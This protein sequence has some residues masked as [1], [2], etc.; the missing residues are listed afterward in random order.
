M[1]ILLDVNLIMEYY[2]HRD[3][4]VEASKVL[5]A[6]QQG[7][8]N[9]YLSA[10]TFDTLTYLIGNELKRQGIHEPLK[11]DTTRGMLNRLLDYLS[12]VDISQDFLSKGLND[13]SFKDL[14][15]AYQYYCAIENE[16]D[17]IITINTKDFAGEHKEKIPVYSLTE[18]VGNYIVAE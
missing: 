6:A 4:F 10:M 5:K 16:C 7:M 13:K 17:G 15:D 3:L 11:R 9:G 8:F 12:V 1:K 2:A 14:E 18:F